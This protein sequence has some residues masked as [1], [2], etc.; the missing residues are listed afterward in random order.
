M[1]AKKNAPRWIKQ[2]EAI[3]KWPAQSKPAAASN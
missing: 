1:S 3:G 2:L